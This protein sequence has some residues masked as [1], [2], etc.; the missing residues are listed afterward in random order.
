MNLSRMESTCSLETSAEIP[1]TNRGVKTRSI[2]IMVK[3]VV[4]VF[5]ILFGLNFNKVVYYINYLV[6][7]GYLVVRISS[8][9]LKDT[10]DAP[11]SINL[12]FQNL[13]FL[14]FLSV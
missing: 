3:K 13:L 10:S 11:S 9:C 6:I 7:Y 14:P 2:I 12:S 8:V 1:I 4:K 5:M